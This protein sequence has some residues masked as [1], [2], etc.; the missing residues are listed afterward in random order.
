MT[1]MPNLA[2]NDVQTEAEFTL[3]TFSPLIQYGC[4]SQLQLFLCSVYV[5]MCTE[6]VPEPIGPCRGL[7]ESVRSKCLHI[8]QNFGFPWPAALNCSK[9]PPVN[10][11]QHM[12]MEGPSERDT[13]TSFAPPS[14]TIKTVR[15]GGHASPC[16]KYAKSTSYVYVNRS[17]RCAPLCD[18]DILFT[19]SE[20]KLAEVWLSVSAA[21]CFLSTLLALLTLVVDTGGSRFRYPERPLAFLAL[22]YNLSS[23]GWG[24]RAIAGRAAV[25]CVP[26]QVYPTRMLLAQ[27]GLRNAKCAVVFLLLYYFGNAGAVW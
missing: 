10:N 16:T 21:L 12:C 3:Q 11:H 15:P 7:C 8:L 20:K 6:K 13:G 27:D 14:G 5:P 25:S 1:G 26:D 22:C 24:V 9:F 2:G 18:K 17:G 19:G 23:I 4:S